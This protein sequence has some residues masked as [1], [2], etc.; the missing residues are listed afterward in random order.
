MKGRLFSIFLC[1]CLIVPVFAVDQNKVKGEFSGIKAVIEDIVPV[2]SPMI[3]TRDKPGCQMLTSYVTDEDGQVMQMLQL[4]A[5][6][7]IYWYI[8]YT[9]L[10]NTNVSFH[11]IW[12]GPEYYEYETDFFSAKYKNYNYAWVSTNNNWLKGVYTLTIIAE[13]DNVRAG[14]E[15]VMTCRV[16]LY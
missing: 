10:F 12:S 1:L 15:A 13:H 16:R 4:S 11:F 2:V 14:S 9:A 8:E 6:D 3:L 5:N 7:T